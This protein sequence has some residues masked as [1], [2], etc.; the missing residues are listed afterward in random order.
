MD[1]LFPRK[2]ETKTTQETYDL[3]DALGMHEGGGQPK[4][5]NV[6]YLEIE[7]ESRVFE[8]LL[9][10]TGTAYALS[11]AVGALYGLYLGVT[12]AKKKNWSVIRNNILGKT[13]ST[14]IKTA[15]QVGAIAFMYH[16]GT[17]GADYALGKE[18]SL[19]AIYISAIATGFLYNLRHRMRRRLM[20]AGIGAVLA[21]GIGV[22]TRRIDYMAMNRMV[23]SYS[24]NK[25]APEA[26]EYRK[27]QPS[28][29]M[30]QEEDY[31]KKEAF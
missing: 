24:D 11:T 21:T 4:Q 1:R 9:F 27:D 31:N 28:I 15:N 5:E 19:E 12:T 16:M 23:T 20:G 6:Q 18:D 13:G 3:Q 14:A 17:L 30:S 26:L 7:Q 22:Y 25:E 8:H 29:P 2:P 10:F